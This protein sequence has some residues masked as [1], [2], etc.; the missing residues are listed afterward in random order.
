MLKYHSVQGS[1]CKST[2]ATQHVSLVCSVPKY[3]G[4]QDLYTKLNSTGRKLSPLTTQESESSSKAPGKNES[5]ACLLLT[6]ESTNE[7]AID[8]KNTQHNTKVMP[9][10]CLQ[11]TIH[12]T[13]L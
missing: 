11:I 12:T 6:D 13:P 9:T 8:K 4:S 7:T 2:R 1:W 3:Y 5:Q 10:Q